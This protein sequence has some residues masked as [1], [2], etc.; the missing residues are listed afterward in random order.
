MKKNKKS[1][2]KL[3]LNKDVVSN[4]DKNSIQGGTIVTL[5]CPVTIFCPTR[6]CFTRFNCETLNI[7]ECNTTIQTLDPRGCGGSLVDGCQSALGCQTVA[8]CF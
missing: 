4:L 7:I 5:A 3:K 6:F 2:K 1:L 8:G